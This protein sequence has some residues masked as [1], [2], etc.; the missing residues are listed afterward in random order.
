MKYGGT[1]NIK[2]KISEIDQ[3]LSI[4]L[5]LYFTYSTGMAANRTKKSHQKNDWDNRVNIYRIEN[6][7]TYKKGGKIDSGYSFDCVRSIIYLRISV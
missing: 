5:I 1:M 3:P 6:D 2:M 7:S 4:S